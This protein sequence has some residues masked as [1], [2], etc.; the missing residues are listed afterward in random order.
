[1][2]SYLTK[3]ATSQD[4]DNLRSLNDIKV[5][6][7]QATVDEAIEQQV[8]P[9]LASHLGYLFSRD[10]LVIYNESIYLN[11]SSSLVSCLS[12]H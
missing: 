6:V 11:D 8:D 2:A 5:D 10:P 1:M 9:V 4:Y 12:L 7:D 3:P